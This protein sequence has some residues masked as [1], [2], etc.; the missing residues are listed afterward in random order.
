MNCPKCGLPVEPGT[1]FCTN[2]GQAINV[3]EQSPPPTSP[4]PA[5]S[6]KPARSGRNMLPIIAVIAVVAVVAIAAIALALGGGGSKAGDDGITNSNSHLSMTVNSANGYLSTEPYAQADEGNLLVM[7]YAN[8]TNRDSTSKWISP[9]YLKLTCSDDIAYETSMMVDTFDSTQLSKNEKMDMYAAFEIPEGVTPK[10]LTYDDGT[11]SITVDLPSGFADLTL[12]VYVNLE[13][14]SITDADSG[15]ISFQPEEGNKFVNV[16]VK[17]TNL[18]GKLLDTEIYHFKLATADGQVHNP[19]IW[20]NP[21]IPDGL[22]PGAQATMVIPFEI[23]V[24]TTPTQL[25]YNNFMSRTNVN[26]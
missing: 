5:A 23:S 8:L 14:V 17:L 2:C 7:I 21:I 16:T 11:N 4:A 9:F 18:M 3:Q 26:I 10:A 1:A 6:A 19:T 13:V 25:Q 12:P 15:Y 24:D 20:V 22:Q